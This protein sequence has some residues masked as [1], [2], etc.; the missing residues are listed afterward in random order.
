MHG[1]EDLTITAN[2]AGPSGSR[3][4]TPSSDWMMTTVCFLAYTRGEGLN[5]I[6][7][8]WT[9]NV[10]KCL[11]TSSQRHFL[12][13]ELKALRICLQD[14]P[15]RVLIH[16][17]AIVCDGSAIMSLLLWLR[18]AIK[19]WSALR[20]LFLLADIL[21]LIAIYPSTF[22]LS[23]LLTVDLGF[24]CIHLS[25]DRVHPHLS[26]GHHCPLICLEFF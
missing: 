2:S 16:D 18:H 9:F 15:C 26:D 14:W 8:T 25:V 3:W 7:L 19:G 23:I 12:L 13:T 20:K 10:G 5:F 6:W 17:R 4:W 21:P 24:L 11:E 1:L 22:L